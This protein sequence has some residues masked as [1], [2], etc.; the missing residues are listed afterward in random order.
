M[1]GG[2]EDAV[3]LD[4]ERL[5]QRSQS[6]EFGAASDDRECDGL[7]SAADLRVGVEQIGQAFFGAERADC[8][9]Y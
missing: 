9:D 5:G 8:A 7:V 1:R 3:I 2:F 6:S 4:A